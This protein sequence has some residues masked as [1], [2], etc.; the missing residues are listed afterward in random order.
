MSQNF[1][2]QPVTKNETLNIVERFHYSKIL[3]RLTK[4]FLGGFINGEL[5]A[6]MTLG[7]GVKP[8]A[9][10]K[11]LF[12]SLS[13]RDYYEIGKL[14]LDDKMPRNSETQFLSSCFSYVKAHSPQTKLIFTW[15]DGMLGKVGYVYQAA[16]FLYGGYIWTDTYFTNS[17]EKIHPRSTRALCE[18]N[19][20]EVGRPLSWLTEGFQLRRGITHYRGKQFRYVS[21]LCSRREKEKLLAESSVRWS[22]HHPKHVDLAW[23]RR[24]NGRFVYCKQ[25]H[26]VVSLN[27]KDV[28]KV[29]STPHDAAKTQ[30]FTAQIS[31]DYLAGLIDA[32]GSISITR[33]NY[34][35]ISIYNTNKNVG[36]AVQKFL[37]NGHISLRQ[38]WGT[39]L[40]KQTIHVYRLNGWWQTV[41]VMERISPYLFLNHEKSMRIYGAAKESMPTMTWGYVAGF[42]DGEG[43]INYKVRDR[44]YQIAI[45]NKAKWLLESICKF[46]GFGSVYRRSDDPTMYD[47][48]I[49]SHNE[50]VIF[51]THLL[52][53]SIVKRDNLLE[54]LGFIQSKDWDMD[55]KGGHKLAHVTDDELCAFYIDQ[56]FS[57][58]DLAAKYGVKYNPMYQR[59]LKAGFSLRGLGT[60]Q[61]LKKP[62]A[63]DN[64]SKEELAKKYDSGMSVDKLADGYGVKRGEMAGHL[65]KAG[66]K[67]RTIAKLKDIPNEEFAAKW[68]K[69]GAVKT[70]GLYGVSKQSVY[71]HLRNMRF[72]H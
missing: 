37:G 48:H 28:L 7:W 36:I 60:N 34:P 38:P 23:K 27:A 25:P 42:T 72:S 33:T 35:S 65:R 71:A 58:R 16:N 11:K 68:H 19:S 29:L 52:P 6:I 1:V 51:I 12:P 30:D 57:I 2:I 39:H 53:F 17:G 26:Y 66:I 56:K 46:I 20:K 61:T 24:V 32:D 9:T 10:I 22:L 49:N 5:V 69:L 54:A 67:M 70:A 59:L 47:V 21:F 45:S 14:C 64:V 13:T 8:K 43:S 63:L 15:S 55:E 44:S 62:S 50:Q 4:L 41:P 3:P 40:G 18:E 31:W